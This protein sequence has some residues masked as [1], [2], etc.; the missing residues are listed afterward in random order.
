MSPGVSVRRTRRA[1]SRES[2]NK[3]SVDTTRSSPFS[4]C[5]SWRL[6]PPRQAGASGRALRAASM[7]TQEGIARRRDA[8][9]WVSTSGCEPD[10]NGRHMGSCAAGALRPA[11][12]LGGAT[13]TV[14]SCGLA[15]A[16]RSGRGWR[17]NEH[18]E[19]LATTF[20]RRGP[21]SRADDGHAHL[22]YRH[23]DNRAHRLHER[24]ACGCRMHCTHRCSPPRGTG[25]PSARPPLTPR[26][27]TSNRW[28]T[29]RPLDRKHDDTHVL[30]APPMCLRA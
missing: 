14:A 29:R 27:G 12:R 13:L 9:L 30:P 19:P 10:F 25:S 21:R 20:A 2:G 8:R 18:G 4:C 15:V 26:C 28:P 7:A 6:R 3:G 24:T 16:Y 5:A 1:C 22:G 17:Q 11:A 23:R